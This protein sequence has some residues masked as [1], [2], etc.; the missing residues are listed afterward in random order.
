MKQRPQNIWQRR[1]HRQ[2]FKYRNKF[3]VTVAGVFK[4]LP[5]NTHLPVS[6]LLSYVSNEEFLDN[7]DTWYF[8]DLAW[9]KLAASTYIVLTDHAD[10][11]ISDLSLMQ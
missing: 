2:T 3:I 7:G 10:I 5:P 1:S 9:T 8:G 6:I 4:D 11:K